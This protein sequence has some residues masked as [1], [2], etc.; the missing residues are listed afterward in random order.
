MDLDI[1][2]NRRLDPLLRFEIV[3]PV[4]RPVGVSNDLMFAAKGHPFMDQVIHNLV[5]FNHIYLSHYPTV[6]FSTGPMFVSASYG[7][8]VDAHGPAFPSTPSQP[9]IGFKGVRVLP[10][11]LY[12]KNAKPAEV[13]DAFFKHFYGSSWHAGDAGFLI[14]LRDHGRLLMFF[15]ACIV[16]Y[17]LCKTVLP[18]ALYSFRRRS[19]HRPSNSRRRSQGRRGDPQWV[20]LPFQTTTTTTRHAPENFPPKRRHGVSRSYSQTPDTRVDVDMEMTRVGAGGSGHGSGHKPSSSSRHKSSASSAGNVS[21]SR[22]TAAPVAVSVAAPKPQRATLP[23]FQL[24]EDD[25]DEDGNR[26]SSPSSHSSGDEPRG[27]LATW[28][29]AAAA[30][31]SGAAASAGVGELSSRP[32]S[33]SGGSQSDYGSGRSGS[34]WRQATNGVLLLPAYALSRMG[35]PGAFGFGGRRGEGEGDVESDE[36]SPSESLSSLDSSASGGDVSRRRRSGGAGSGVVGWAAQMLPSGWRGP[37][38]SAEEKAH[39]QAGAGYESDQDEGVER[40]SSKSTSKSKSHAKSPSDSSGRKSTSAWLDVDPEIAGA[41]APPRPSPSPSV[42]L[43]PASAATG[44]LPYDDGA[45]SAAPHSRRLSIPATGSTGSKT[46]PPPPP[47]VEK[48]DGG[49]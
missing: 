27:L 1:G 16:V 8:Y 29:A 48:S 4:T 2:C 14:F 28:S 25:E 38:P 35:S 22:S 7:L 39:L 18:K 42:F 19:A 26:P 15:G 31:V 36:L 30:T 37:V 33:S 34:R 43:R 13:P 9:E 32:G 17:G 20:G 3:L 11:S 12:G 23:F 45:E 44:D 21:G 46:P 47:Y 41:A 6:M 24:Q 5:T 49:S 40:R 10:K